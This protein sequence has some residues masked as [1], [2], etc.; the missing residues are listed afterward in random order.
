[1]TNIRIIALVALLGLVGPAHA[2]RV[3]EQPERP[4]ELTLSQLTL[5]RDTGGGVT[6]RECDL[7]GIST[8]RFIEGAKFVVDG[9]PL[10]YADFLQ[11]V[12]DLRGSVTASDATVI[13]V[14]VD[15]TTERV[16]RIALRRPR[17]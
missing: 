10:P 8:R 6:L 17:H 11:I 15:K 13:N 14:Y 7:C 12:K 4:F 1:M 3:I 2:F 5:P 16:T 9:R